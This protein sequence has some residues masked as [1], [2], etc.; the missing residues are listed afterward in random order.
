[1]A[2]TSEFSENLRELHG[3]SVENLVLYLPET[4][5]YVII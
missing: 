4:K 1:M 3:D 5:N 2:L